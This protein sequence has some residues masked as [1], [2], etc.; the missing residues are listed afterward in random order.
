MNSGLAKNSQKAYLLI[1]ESH[2][3][4]SVRS[5]TQWKG[6]TPSVDT[7]QVND[8][9]LLLSS[10]LLS[11]AVSLSQSHL[12]GE[13]QIHEANCWLQTSR[14]TLALT[15]LEKSIPWK[16]TT[17]MKSGYFLAFKETLETGWRK[18]PEQWRY[19]WEVGNYILGYETLTTDT[20]FGLKQHVQKTQG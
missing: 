14:L 5:W 3:L 20:T 4:T 1:F 11:R 13:S 10:E 2:W 7:W 19:P 18:M 15:E 8:G 9:S 16:M 12:L 17:W 6:T